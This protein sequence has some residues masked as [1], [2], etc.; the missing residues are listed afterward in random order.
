MSPPLSEPRLFL[1]SLFD[2]AVNAAQPERTLAAFLPPRPSGRLIVVGAGKAAASMARAT[3]A[4]YGTGLSGLVITRYGYS[5]PTH[6]IEVIEAS[7]P[8][9]DLAGVRAT[10]RLLAA[11]SNLTPQD[12]VIFL[13]SGGASALLCAPAQGISLE[14][15]QELTR[16]L[17]RSG[18]PI[19][20][21]NSVRKALSLVKGGRLAEAI[22]PAQLVTL[23]ISDV[24]GDIPSAIGSGPT[25]LG[26]VEQGVVGSAAQSILVKYGIVP[27]EAVQRAL[28]RTQPIAALPANQSFHIV[29]SAEQSLQAAKKASLNL[30]IPC[31]ILSDRLEGEAREVAKVLAA[32]ARRSAEQDEPF[33]APRVLLSGGE[34]T[35]TLRGEGR[36]GP[37]TELLLSMAIE[38]REQAGVYALSGDTDGIDGSESNA[39][40]IITPDT[41]RRAHALG[42]NPKTYLDRNDAYGFFNALGDLVETGPTY[43]NVND[44]RAILIT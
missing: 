28:E 15:K 37:N 27:S 1:R 5:Q 20:E 30:G 9:P 14:E 16:A 22:A 8:V 34:T 23:A 44:F 32:L 2:A 26:D 24:A 35:V 33:S 4:H 13:I 29:A 11:V 43:T 12:L 25:V 3:E 42:L 31:A 38:L 40:A 36:G 19:S 10:Q 41:L 17:L 18:A 21:V 6:H 7:H 39:G